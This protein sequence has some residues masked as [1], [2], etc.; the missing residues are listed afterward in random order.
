MRYY[1]YLDKNFLKTLFGGLENE[2]FEIDFVE[3]M[4]KKSYNTNKGI[5]IDPLAEQGSKIEKKTLIEEKKEKENLFEECK[6]E[7]FEKSKIGFC[8]NDQNGCIVQVEKKY[9]NVDDIT[10]I[11]NNNFY[12]NL[13]N[14]ITKKNDRNIKNKVV[15]EIGYINIYNENNRESKTNQEESEFFFINNSYVWFDNKLL[16]TKVS[17]LSKM[18]CKVKVIGYK[19][20]EEDRENEKNILKAIAI[21]I[22]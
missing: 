12:H 16:E 20:N 14:K 4:V 7:K 9:V 19:M 8:Y 18:C 3:Y 11:K 17:T 1:L 6:N 13:I 5:T 22:D 21:Y 15:E 2:D 10:T